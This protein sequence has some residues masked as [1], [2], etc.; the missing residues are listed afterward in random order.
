M[1]VQP[2]S[3]VGL[4]AIDYTSSQYEDLGCDPVLSD[5]LG[6]CAG[7]AGENLEQPFTQPSPARATTPVP[8][9]TQVPPARTAP[10]PRPTAAKA[11][12]LDQVKTFIAQNQTPILIG[13]GALLLLAT[14]GGRRR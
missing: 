4:G 9:Q 2:N 3:A 11:G 13:S 10:A 5:V 14:L 6:Y 1:Y 7:S 8:I 12:V